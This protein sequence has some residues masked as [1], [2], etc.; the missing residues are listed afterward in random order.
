MNL[1][2]YFNELKRRNVFKSGIAYLVLSWIL[3]QVSETILPAINAPDYL[4]KTIL[5]VLS[6]G[7]PVWLLFSW[8]Y[9]I[10]PEGLKKTEDVH[11]TT[12]IAPRT[13]NRLNKII[14]ALLAIAIV[15]MFFDKFWPEE[16]NKMDKTEI[17]LIADP[18]FEDKKAIAVL[19]FLNHSKNTNEE[20]V[21][22]GITEAITLE[23]SKNNSLRV[24][25]RT[26][27]MSYKDESKLSSEIA[28]E[29]G[30]DY[31]LEGSV[32]TDNDSIRVTVQ[33]IDPV[34]SEKHIWSNI[35]HQKTENI[36][37]MI[38][39]LSVDIANEINSIMTPAVP[40]SN[41]QQVDAKA[42]DL[43][44]KGRHLWKQ[45]TN[46]TI[47]SSIENLTES[48]KL[49]SSFAPAY[50]SLAEAYITLNQFEYNNEKKP[51]NREKSRE[52]INRALEMDNTLGEA[53][54]T[55]GNILG[56]FDWDWKG[57]K[58]MLDKGLQLN[59]NN[60]YGHKLLS[61]Y[62]LVIGDYNKAISE[63]FIAEKLDPLN[64]MIGLQAGKVYYVANQ[65][66]KAMEQSYKLLE[67]FPEFGLAYSRLGF[68]HWIKGEKEEARNSFL[69][70]QEIRNNQAMV[71]AYKEGSLEDGIN[72]WLLSVEKE[73]PKFCTWPGLTAQV[74]M[75][76]DDKEKALE[77][78]EIAFKYHNEHLP[79]MLLMPEFKHLYNE[80][81]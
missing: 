27:A 3:I 35:Y 38:G 45:Q 28:K 49:D 56:K 54:I 71:K 36:I 37:P 32:L 41:F 13:S 73:D 9:E 48:I 63:S 55:K 44:L 5:Y 16:V 17:S 52:A 23:L 19:S 21:V 68:V 61:D 25:S 15:M 75:A 6:I 51:L 80:S 22:D 40:S 62:Y 4:F 7:F 8:I 67:L 46:Q 12:S 50:V 77:Y 2:T 39:N 30:S 33:L 10:T 42:Y 43:Y 64:P 66:D 70:L 65:Y 76:I 34:P 1:R 78:L 74:Y 72:F 60:A 29:L 26:S 20:Y 14:I 24:I 18:Q 79:I 31:L 69:R 81:R 58:K 53:Y 57:M 59:P 47:G 11:P